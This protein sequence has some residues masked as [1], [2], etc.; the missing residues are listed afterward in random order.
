[1]GLI[2]EAVKRFDYLLEV[3]AFVRIDSGSGPHMLDVPERK[4]DRISI[5][6]VETGLATA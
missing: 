5:A 3:I 6:T 4:P 2:L 1:V